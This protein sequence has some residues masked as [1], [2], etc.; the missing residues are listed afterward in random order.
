MD[1]KYRRELGLAPIES[2]TLKMEEKRGKTWPPA[3]L[4]EVLVSVVF[5]WSLFLLSGFRCSSPL[6]ALLFTVLSGVY[7]AF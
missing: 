5:V 7:S 4:A 2:L 1:E 3:E 6:T